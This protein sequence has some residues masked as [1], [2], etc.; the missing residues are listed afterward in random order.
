MLGMRLSL[1][2]EGVIRVLDE[3]TVD[4]L[5][6]DL[7]LLYQ[8]GQLLYQHQHQPALGAG[9]DRV[10]LQLG[11]AQL[12]VNPG[13]GA[14]GLRMALLAQEEGDLLHRSLSSCLQ[15]GVGL[16]EGQSGRLVQL[17]EQLQGHRIVR[18]QTGGELVDQPSLALDE[19]F[20][21]PAEGFEFL[22][23][24]AIRLEGTKV[25]QIATTGPGQQV[26]VDG[27]GLGPSRLPVAVH[28]LGIQGIDRET[29]LQKRRDEKAV[30]GL[31]KAGN[32]LGITSNVQKES[33]ELGQAR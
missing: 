23:Q 9:G 5:V 10:G 12:G 6:V 14:L 15:S 2:Y 3:K 19:D 27:I 16:E 11:L 7:D 30:V 24:G 20:Q 1:T 25:C 29:G 32:L 18:F 4:L 26:G 8:E 21:V 22:D 17:G 31:H 28:C 33:L 13:G